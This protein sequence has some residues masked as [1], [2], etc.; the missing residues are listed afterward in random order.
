[1]KKISLSRGKHALV[2]DEDFE[3]LNQYR[4]YINE[5][6]DR[7]K[8]YAM[9]SKLI[10]ESDDYVGNKIYMHRFIL[11][12]T[13]KRVVI[14]HKN[15]NTLDNRRSNLNLVDL[16]KQKKEKEK[17]QKAA[18]KKSKKKKSLL[19]SKKTTK[20]TTKKKASK[21]KTGKKKPT[22]KKATKKGTTGKKKSRK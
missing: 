3:W 2:D 19:Q 16:D 13:K 5:N 8:Q 7:T 6:A 17:T 9:R 1:M 14:K 20:K 10:D 21:K 18:K 4:W 12:I 11:G 22:K 15:G